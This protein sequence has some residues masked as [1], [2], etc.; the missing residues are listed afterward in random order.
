MFVKPLVWT[1]FSLHI[2]AGAEAFNMTWMIMDVTATFLMLLWAKRT[3][4]VMVLASQNIV[5]PALCSNPQRLGTQIVLLLMTHG[6]GFVLSGVSRGRLGRWRYLVQISDKRVSIESMQIIKMI[7][8][9]IRRDPWMRLW[10]QFCQFCSR[11]CFAFR[12]FSKD[13]G[14]WK[15]QKR[16]ELAMQ[17]L[18]FFGNLLCQNMKNMESVFL[19]CMTPW[20]NAVELTAWAKCPSLFLGTK[21]NQSRRPS[22]C[23]SEEAPE[24]SMLLVTPWW[25]CSCSFR[26]EVEFMG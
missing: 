4:I 24:E 2:G 21:G 11:A 25:R 17:T 26:L 20:V 13:K 23:S 8:V 22:L 6:H 16:A 1:G 14:G 12:S 10:D 15:Q 3:M 19:F 5:V 9:R 7:P 18:L